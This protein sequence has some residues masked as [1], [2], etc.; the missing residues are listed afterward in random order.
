VPAYLASPRQDCWNCTRDS[1]TFVKPPAIRVA[2]AFLTSAFDVIL[3]QNVPGERGLYG[4]GVIVTKEGLQFSLTL[5][6]DA[7]IPWRAHHEEK[8]GSYICCVLRRDDTAK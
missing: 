1:A 6:E 8:C 4:E 2:S 3:D 5:I 7:D